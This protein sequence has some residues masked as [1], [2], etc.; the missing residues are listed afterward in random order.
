[1]DGIEAINPTRSGGVFLGF[2]IQDSNGALFVLPSQLNGA[3][4]TSHETP[5][6]AGR[7]PDRYV[8]F[9][10]VFKAD[11]R[12]NICA[13]SPTHS[14]YKHDQSQVSCFYCFYAEKWL[15]D[16]PSHFPYRGELEP[17][18]NLTFY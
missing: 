14:I 13:T 5:G 15:N 2:F 12:S 9:V 3:E 4:Y 7:G 1:M 6:F 8:G 16:P 11:D 17:S 10:V 18:I